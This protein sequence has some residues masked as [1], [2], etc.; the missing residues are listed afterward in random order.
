VFGVKE[1]AVTLLHTHTHART[2][3]QGERGGCMHA[4]LLTKNINK[5]IMYVLPN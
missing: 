1:P 3:T 5:N 2:Q 4:N